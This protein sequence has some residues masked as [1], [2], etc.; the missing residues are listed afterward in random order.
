MH[1]RITVTLTPVA[2]DLGLSARAQTPVALTLAASPTLDIAVFEG[3]RGEPGPPGPA[4]DLTAINQQIAVKADM[5]FAPTAAY[6]PGTLPAAVRDLANGT[7]DLT[8][9]DGGNF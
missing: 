2:A 7:G 9:I 3:L 6:P 1:E 5:A 4:P 8:V